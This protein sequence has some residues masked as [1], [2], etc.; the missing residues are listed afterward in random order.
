MASVVNMDKKEFIES[1]P[2]DQYSRQ[3]IVKDLIDN[4]I[5][6]LTS[7]K[8]LSIIDL[9]GHKGKTTEF[10]SNDKVTILDV[11]NE[12]YPNY[13]KG[14]ATK[15]PFKD[16]TF[17]IACSF[18]VF[19]H[20]P[21]P[22]RQAFINEALRISKYGIFLTMPVDGDKKVSVAEKRLNRFHRILFTKDHRWLKE[23]IDYK[24][25]TTTEV[26][27]YVKKS[28]GKAISIPSNQIGDWQL[29]QSLLFLSAQNPNITDIVKQANSWY[30]QHTLDLDSGIDVGYR[31]IFFVTKKE[32]AITAVEKVLKD[33]SSRPS[34]DFVTVNTA[35]FE[36]FLEALAQIGQSHNQLLN[37]Y[38]KVSQ[39]KKTL[40]QELERIEKEYSDFR[41]DIL[42]SS[43]WK[44]TKPLRKI[45]TIYKKR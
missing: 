31:S 21:R 36:R 8:K 28:G 45:G 25:P 13:V 3:Y 17:D 14:D 41:T 16:G 20:I 24:I 27:S 1:L 10:H 34:N 2:F 5:R 9:G 29:F 38:K 32:K 6:Q 7:K 12:K 18:D 44:V 33:F 35:A 37:Q 30:N 23:H 43:S 4:S 19:E 40:A 11:F 42:N 22:K 15:T 26:L 39:T